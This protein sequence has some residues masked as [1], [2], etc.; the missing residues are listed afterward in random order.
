MFKSWQIFVFSL[1]PLALV[2]AG[3]I[4]GSMDG[5][6]AQR[7]VFPTRA[8][9]AEN[10]NTPPPTPSAPGETVIQ[11]VAQ[12]LAFDQRALS[13]TAG[14]SVTIQ[15]DNRDASVLHNFALYGDQTLAQK[16]F[17]GDL[18]T[19]P[20]VEN[21]TFDAPAAGTYYFRCD[22]HPDTMNGSFTVR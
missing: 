18:V 21:Y 15:L 4:I 11:L 7:E 2:F 5:I 6:D 10:G 19:G 17:V 1:I 20:V 16:V 8:P 22:V 3:V 9:H 14:A 13:A 12:N